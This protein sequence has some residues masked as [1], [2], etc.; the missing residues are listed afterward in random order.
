MPELLIAILAAGASRR[1]GTSKQL[2]RVA[3]ETLLHR[4]CRIALEA[5]LGRVVAILGCDSEPCRAAIADLPVEVAIN[6]EWQEGMSSSVR[7]A[8]QVAIDGGCAGLLI[9]LVDQY[10][11]GSADLVHLAKRW[12]LHPEQIAISTA[13]EYQGPPA[14]FGT[15][16]FAELQRLHGDQ[17]AKSLLRNLRAETIQKVT[18]P[19]AAAD[20]D[21]VGDVHRLKFSVPYRPAKLNNS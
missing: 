8:V 3:N 7:K 10:Q 11:L 12:D 19:H 21:Q 20:C 16:F 1:L 18:V 15:S 5:Q 4:Q 13:G 6:S 14:L 2:L 9:I 17:G